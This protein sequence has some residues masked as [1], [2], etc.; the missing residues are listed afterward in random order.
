MRS[1]LIIIIRITRFE[2]KNACEFNNNKKKNVRDY[3]NL[4]INSVN[5]I[6]SLREN[7]IKNTN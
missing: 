2:Y 3:F 7:K 5:N 4:S 6:L 1:G